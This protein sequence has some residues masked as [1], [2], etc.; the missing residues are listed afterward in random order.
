MQVGTTP[1]IVTAS[2]GVAT[3]EHGGCLVHAAQLVKA[4]DLAVYNAK[5]NGRNCVRVFSLRR[6]EPKAAA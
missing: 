4:A 3:Y 1:I 6:T 5:T 2:I